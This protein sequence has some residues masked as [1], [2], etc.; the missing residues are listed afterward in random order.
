MKT[1]ALFLFLS[2]CF[3]ASAS[4]QKAATPPPTSTTSTIETVRR[5]G[6]EFVVTTN[7][8]FN[9]IPLYAGN[10]YESI[11]LLEEV[12]TEMSRDV[13]GMNSAMKVEAWIGKGR[14]PDKKAWTI[15]ADADV[16]EAGDP[17]YKVTK[18]GCCASMNTHVW[19]N[20][21]SGQ[22]V[23]TGTNNLVKISVPNT[24]GDSLDRYVTFHSNMGSIEAP[25]MKRLKDVMGV[26][27]YGTN[28][29][30]TYRIVLRASDS[31]TFD[32]GQPEV[33]VAHQQET[34]FAE[35]DQEQEVAL[36]AYDGKKSASSLSDFT[37]ILK[38]EDK[39]QITI[40]FKNDAPVLSEAK[41]PAKI[42][43]ELPSKP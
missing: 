7:R 8:K 41:V 14:K 42:K 36:W 1:K 26:L 20:L 39:I 5:E 33:G 2:L 30:A 3:C 11:L 4:A 19:Y 27:Q 17:F 23:F 37:V 32:L 10:G 29:R 25:E 6:I 43:L 12:R 38:W 18:Y 21:L 34:K 40:P 22:R 16:A 9:Y 24:G 15:K 28:K 13:E 35:D 31:E